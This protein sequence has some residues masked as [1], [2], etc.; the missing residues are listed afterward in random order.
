MGFSIRN[1]VL[2]FGCK[3]GPL[4]IPFEN[5]QSAPFDLAVYKLGIKRVVSARHDPSSRYYFGLNIHFVKPLLQSLSTVQ[6]LG[7]KEAAQNKPR[8]KP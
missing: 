5:P 8:E 4:I 2:S 6:V 1:E 3:Q 7:V